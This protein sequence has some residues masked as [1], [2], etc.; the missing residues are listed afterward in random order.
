[1]KDGIRDKWAE[2]WGNVK[3]TATVAW[4][5]VRRGFDT[6]A[7]GLTS[8]FDGVKR[9]IG[10]IWDGLKA[11]VKAP[12]KFWIETVY[13]KGIVSVWNKTAAKIPGVP[14]LKP[15]SMPKGF[16]RGGILPGQSSWRQGDDQLVPMRRGEGV[17]VSE[18]MRDPYERARL[19]AVN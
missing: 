9:G 4:T 15:M 1:V 2:L 14:D 17:Y 10:K 19:H 18:A 3:R 6:F 12:I 16:A 8:A 7:E 11:L 13:N 5:L